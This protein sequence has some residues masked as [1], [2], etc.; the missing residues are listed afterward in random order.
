MGG[1]ITGR[2]RVEHGVLVLIFG[3][4]VGTNQFVV[5]GLFH[6]PRF[7][8]TFDFGQ[9]TGNGRAL[10]RGPGTADVVRTCVDGVV[11]VA[12]GGKR[13]RDYWGFLGSVSNTI[14]LLLP[15]FGGE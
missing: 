6:K 14:S 9:S 10:R 13:G 8:E 11:P 2:G 4:R 5:H 12:R 3:Q 15:W 7:H 1:S